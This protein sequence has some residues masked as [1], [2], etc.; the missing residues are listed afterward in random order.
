[1][2]EDPIDQLLA[3]LEQRGWTAE[4]GGV[5]KGGWQ[6]LR[7]NGPWLLLGTEHNARAFDVGVA[8]SYFVPWG[9][10]GGASRSDGGRASTPSRR[11]R[12]DS[13]RSSE[14]A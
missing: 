6:L 1:M 2:A 10:P 9:E 5:V 4:F 7:D 11:A 14:R 3:V 12:I 8:D 13:S